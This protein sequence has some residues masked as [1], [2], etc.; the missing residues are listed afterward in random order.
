MKNWYICKEYVTEIR[1]IK[2]VGFL[3]S[4]RTN[5]LY[6]Y[7]YIQSE[8]KNLYHRDSNCCLI[9]FNIYHLK[10]NIHLHMMHMESGIK[11]GK[12]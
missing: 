8:F 6:Y 10:I 9:F 1:I 11:T 7:I 5:I 12:S 2:F 3:C 4:D